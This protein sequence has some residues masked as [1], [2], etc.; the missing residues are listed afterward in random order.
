[1]EPRDLPYLEEEILSQPEL[2]LAKP[3]KEVE[4]SFRDSPDGQ[5]RTVE[6]VELESRIGELDSLRRDAEGR[7]EIPAVGGDGMLLVFDFGTV[8]NGMPM[9]EVQGAAGTEVD[10]LCTPYLLNGRFTANIVDSQLIDRIIL[11]GRE[12]AWEAFYWKP[13]RYMGLVVRSD[14][15]PTFLK[16]VGLHQIS[17]PFEMKGSFQTPENPRLE[18]YWAAAA[19]TIE[20]CT[21]D[22]Y[23]DNYRERRQYVQTAY[24]AALGNAWTY[25]D[26]ALYR[27]CLKQAA[28]EQQANG[29]MP[30][31]APR[32][33][34][35]YLVFLDSNTAWLRGLRNFLLYSGDEETVRELLPSGRKLM[36]LLH[37]FTN[38]LGLIDN[39]PFAYWLDHALIDRRGANFYLNGHYLGAVEDFAEVLAWLGMEAEADE[40]RERAALLRASL[41][42]YF[43]NDT[44]KL[45]CDA[46]VDG[47]Q[48]SMFSEHANGM[49]LAMGVAT[50]EQGRAVAEQLLVDDDHDYIRRESG[51]IMVTPASSYLLH[52]GLC[53]YGHAKASLEMFQ[54]RFDKMFREGQN[55]TLWEEWWLDRTGRSGRFTNKTRSDAQT[56][57]AFPP[58]L[59]GEYVLGL[60][61]MTP[62]LKQIRLAL[63]ACGLTRMEG[64]LPTPGGAVSVAWDLGKGRLVVDIRDDLE[65]EL[66]LDSLAPEQTR[67]ISLNG[68]QVAASAGT[69]TLSK[70]KSHVQF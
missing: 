6:S 8:I 20:V 17:Y 27:R 52:L 56:E 24:Y 9:L 64:T 61:P 62:G 33:G 15:A 46:L 16:E 43:W 13:T 23:T 10:I 70:G 60:Q 66:D 21:T 53:R 28:E 67:A 14:E 12:D 42:K 5:R 59:F 41:R 44:K 19:K 55:N 2:V 1:L 47:V 45:F 38:T 32:F 39:P 7:M 3:L 30:S 51:L 11:S 57:S 29:I 48:S 31:S 69:I 40:H 35:G 58:A 4:V 50:V 26:W 49:A 34:E 25:G 36:A 37:S 22:A 18:Q 63:Q 54:D 65:V 68:K